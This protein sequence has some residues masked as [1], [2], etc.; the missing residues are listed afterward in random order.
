MESS[1]DI[2][3]VVRKAKRRAMV[4]VEKCISG[5]LVVMWLGVCEI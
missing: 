3:A 5:G 1:G 4:G 2:C